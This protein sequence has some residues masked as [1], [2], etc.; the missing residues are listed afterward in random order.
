MGYAE[1]VSTFASLKA[2]NARLSTLAIGIGATIQR[3]RLISVIV[4]VIV[5][6]AITL[7]LLGVAQVSE[8]RKV[9]Q[10]AAVVTALLYMLAVVCL[11][12]APFD[13][14]DF[15]ERMAKNAMEQAQI[16]QENN[17]S[18]QG[19][20]VDLQSHCQNLETSIV[21]FRKQNANFARRNTELQGQ[22]D[23]ISRVAE[24]LEKTNTTLTQG[25]QDLKQQNEELNCA[26]TTYKEQNDRLKIAVNGLQQITTSMTNN[27][28]VIRAICDET[29]EALTHGTGEFYKAALEL[30]R[31]N[32]E[33]S[34]LNVQLEMLTREFARVTT[35]LKALVEVAEA[36]EA[37][38]NL[39]TACEGASRSLREFVQEGT[40]SVLEQAWLSFEIE[41]AEA[42]QAQRD[43]SQEGLRTLRS[44]K[45]DPPLDQQDQH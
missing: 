11:Y 41:M 9:T 43:L 2:K 33:N 40:A 19:Y 29:S 1:D 39:K 4:V 13:L 38:K 16:L 20:I 44:L 10:W 36:Q 30:D 22:V 37:F 45:L 27:E 6:A 35:Q 34:R 7:A 31:A 21:D 24:Q 15:G 26:N 17:D 8:L 28:K 23:N 42:L 18:M 5:V 32:Q 25:M 12:N 14:I 3:S